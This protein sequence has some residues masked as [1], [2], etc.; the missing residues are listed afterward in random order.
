MED[1]SCGGVEYN[2]KVLGVMFIYVSG[3]KYVVH[4]PLRRCDGS[5]TENFLFVLFVVR[6]RGGGQYSTFICLFAHLT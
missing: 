2:M 3:V 1:K 5:E 4:H 6:P